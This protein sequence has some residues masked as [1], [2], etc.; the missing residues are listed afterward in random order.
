M[1]AGHRPAVPVA[2]I[3][4]LLTVLGLASVNLSDALATAMTPENSTAPYWLQTGL[5]G[6]Y[7]LLLCGLYLRDRTA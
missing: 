3:V 4:M 2:L 5:I 6:G 1:A 7:F